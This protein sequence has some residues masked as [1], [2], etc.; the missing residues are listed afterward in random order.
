MLLILI[1]G[2]TYLVWCVLRVLG[3]KAPPVETVRLGLMRQLTA[4]TVAAL[5]TISLLGL[6]PAE[7]I[8]HAVQSWI[9]L[10]LFL[11]VMIAIPVVTAIA[12]GGQIS[13]RTLLALVFV[14]AFVF[15]A[16][17]YWDA[18]DVDRPLRKFPPELW[19]PARGVPRASAAA[20]QGMLSGN[21]RTYPPSPLRWPALQW[22]FYHGAEWTVG[23]GSWQSD[24]GG[25]RGKPEMEAIR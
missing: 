21:V 23:L 9:V 15:G 4:W 8:S 1:A 3:P 13:L 17:F 2:I 19:I 12:L 11:A 24:C 16:L 6:A 18:I 5:A 22:V 14:Y 25:S 10:G 7:I 20:L